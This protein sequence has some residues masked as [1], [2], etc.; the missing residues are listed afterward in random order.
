MTSSG[1]WRREKLLYLSWNDVGNYME[2]IFQE[3]TSHKV[4]PSV[5]VGIWRGGL[6]LSVFLANRFHLHRLQVLAITRNLN[7]EKYAQRGEPQLQ[8]AAP[9]MSLRDEDVLIVDDIV[10][11]G[12][13]LE[14]ALAIV[15]QHHP[16]SISTAVIARNQNSRLLPDYYG[17]LADD[18]VVFPWESSANNDAAK[19]P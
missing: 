1:L 7:D 9:T 2:E 5:I 11:D 3:L 19:Q 14:A 13:T 4:R 12:G 6:V 16:R 10:G 8:W 17:Y 15:K 18:W